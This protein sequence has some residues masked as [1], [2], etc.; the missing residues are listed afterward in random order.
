MPAKKNP[1]AET[2]WLNSCLQLVLT[3][4]DFKDVI[5]PTGSVLWQNLLWLQG[6]DLSVVLDPTHDKQAIIHTEKARIARQNVAPSHTLFNQKGFE[7][8][9]LSSKKKIFPMYY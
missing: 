1:D 2:C 5:C 3:A 8:G 4:L 9:S 6:K 7:N